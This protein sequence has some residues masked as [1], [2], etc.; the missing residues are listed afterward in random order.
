MKNRIWPYRR[1]TR[2]MTFGPFGSKTGWV[3]SRHGYDSDCD[4][5]A[6]VA[7]RPVRFPGASQMNGVRPVR[8]V[9]ALALSLSGILMA[10]GP[11]VATG[12]SLVPLS[13]ESIGVI[14]CS[15]TKQHVE[16]YTLLS[17]AD[18]F[19][20]PD[21][22]AI[23]GGTLAR[24]AANLSDTSPYWTNFSSNLQKYG[25]DAV[26]IQMCIR[27]RE[28]SSTG[29]TVDQQNDL[30]DVIGEIQR[31]TGGV[32]IYISPLN[33]F[34]QKDCGL[35]GPYGVPNAIQLA[36]WASAAGLATRGPD[37]GP[38]DHSQ[39]EDDLCHLNETGLVAVGRPLVDFFDFVDLSDG[40]PVA[41]FTYSPTSPVVN[42]QT[43]FQDLSTDDG[44]IV[45]WT[46][47]FDGVVL[48]GERVRI[49]FLQAGTH[50]V[51]LRVTDDGNNVAV[52]RRLVTV[53]TLTDR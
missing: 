21:D 12:E 45:S 46:W 50:T 31:R 39:L 48:T 1:K 36:N 27:D 20:S 18:K 42:E 41:D 33:Q 52:T 35:T 8:T 24:W 26:W 2:V 34:A 4:D 13:N 9:L 51:T 14:G 22:L 37:T 30:I 44:S 23:S 53:R 10:P 32:P 40:P 16:G 19:W 29:M 15:N 7:A 17:N 3:C 43:T 5:P 25:A 49:I 28:A 11:A 6:H 47:S 38:L